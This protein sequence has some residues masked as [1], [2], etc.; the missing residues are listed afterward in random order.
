[1]SN[2]I[3]PSRLSLEPH[4]PLRLPSLED[5]LTS[6]IA[7]RL[8]NC[9]RISHLRVS[10][11]PLPPTPLS[12]ASITDPWGMLFGAPYC[13]PAVLHTPLATLF[14]QP[15]ARGGHAPL[16]AFPPLPF[17]FPLPYGVSPLAIGLRWGHVQS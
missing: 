3:T 8:R 7:L 15:K 2:S 9:L 16:P 1:M 5:A 13:P 12:K 11:T 4:H 6:T 10:Q 14:F 17:P